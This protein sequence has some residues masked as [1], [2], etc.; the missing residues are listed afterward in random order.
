MSRRLRSLRLAAAVVAALALPLVIHADDAKPAP[1]QTPAKPAQATPPPTT[2]PVKAPPPIV[3]RAPGAKPTDP[4]LPPVPASADP[5][6]AQYFTR[7]R[8]P[9]ESMATIQLPPGYHLQLVASEPDI[10]SPVCRLS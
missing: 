8:T 1:S 2:A 6:V 4:P 7:L 9:A 5:A 10:I 3:P